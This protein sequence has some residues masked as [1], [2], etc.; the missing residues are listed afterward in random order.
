MYA[1]ATRNR[2]ACVLVD[3]PYSDT[4][5]DGEEVPVWSVCLGDED[6]EPVGT[7]YTCYTHKRATDLGASMSRDR[8]LEL[9]DESSPA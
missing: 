4:D 9:I 8:R 6:G 3:G 2:P 7:V 1:T 5:R